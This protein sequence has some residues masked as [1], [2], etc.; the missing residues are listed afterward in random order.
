MRHLAVVLA[1]ALTGQ[2][3]AQE[4]HE[5]MPGMEMKSEQTAHFASGTVTKLDEKRGTVTISHG[6]VP[7]LKWPPMT[8]RFAVKDKTVSAKLKPGQK[9]DFAFVKEGKDYVVTEIR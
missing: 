4:K 3:A 1:L 9:I 7:S 8:M 2:A 6:P 5:D